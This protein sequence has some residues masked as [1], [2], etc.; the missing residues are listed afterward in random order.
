MQ[1]SH[2]TQLIVYQKSRALAAR[3]FLVSRSWP[4]E[5]RYSLTDQIRRSARSIGAN[6]AESWAK[7]R[8]EAHFISKLTDADGENHEVEHWLITAHGDGYLSE[9]DFAALLEPKREIGRM[10][11]SMIQNPTP[12][13]LSR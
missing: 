1:I 5:E 12:F 3:V 2:F 4:K 7:R 13:L 11:G 6:T 8:Y 10:L 9:S